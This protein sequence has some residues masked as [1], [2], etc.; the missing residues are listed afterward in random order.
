[1]AD[2][3]E[4]SGSTLSMRFAEDG[5]LIVL[6]PEGQDDHTGIYPS[7]AER[8][9]LEAFVR[10]TAGR[11]L[12]M[13][14]RKREVHDKLTGLLLREPGEELIRERIRRLGTMPFHGTVSVLAIDLDHFSRINKEYGQM[15]GD[16]VLRWAAGVF[17]RR[18]RAADVLVRRGG[19]EFVVFTM[20]GLAPPN[21]TG[22]RDQDP[23]STGGTPSRHAI[24]D[25]VSAAMHNGPM[26]ALRLLTTLTAQPCTVGGNSIQQSATIGVATHFITPDTVAGLDSLY[27]RL[28]EAADERLRNAKTT[29]QRGRVHEASPLTP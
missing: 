10:T 1:M 24:I 11:S 21:R 5:E 26:L 25:S 7:V 19:E 29:N 2:G 15:V 8:T 3:K 9:T 18:T 17:K 20:A 13:R 28:F 22:S 27:E 14:M 12:L 4:F 6:F 23:K 16:E